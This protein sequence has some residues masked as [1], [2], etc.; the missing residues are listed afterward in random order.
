MLKLITF[1][2]RDD[3]GRALIEVFRPDDDFVK[4]AS[5]DLWGPTQDFLQTLSSKSGK[6]YILVNALGASE[7]WGN[8]I[9]GDI[10]PE[11]EL[12]PTD[13]DCGWGYKTF[14]NAGV[15]RHHA[16][17]KDPMHS[18]GRI[19]FTTYNTY[20]HRVELV[21]EIDRVRATEL[22]HGDLIKRIDAGEN[23]A[24]SMGCRVPY[25]VCNKCGHKS[26]TGADHCEH[27][28]SYLNQLIGGVRVGMINIRPKFFDL[29]VV[30]I[31][32]EK[33]SY[34]MAKVA[35][36]TNHLFTENSATLAEMYD[37]NKRS[38]RLRLKE[39]FAEK[40]KLSEILKKIPAMSARVIP[41]VTRA[42]PELSPQLLR[43][44]ARSSLPSALTSTAAAGIL[45]RPR[46]YQH[47]ALSCLGRP[48][49]AESL[50]RRGVVF[51]P[52]SGRDHSV[53]WGAPSMHNRGL[54]SLLAS[55]IPGR[56]ILGHALSKR[57][58]FAGKSRPTPSLREESSPVLEK[59]ASG[60][61]AYREEV[62]TK[63]SS[64][65]A[66]ITTKDVELLSAIWDLELGDS[67]WGGETYGN[68]KTASAWPAMLLG[69][70]PLAYLYGAYKTGKSGGVGEREEG[71]AGFVREHP[72]LATS[73]LVGLT[74]MGDQLRKSGLLDDAVN[75]L[76]HK[77]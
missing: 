1:K 19:V 69:A 76:V 25:D 70:F 53:S 26:R 21:I 59:V 58:Q 41:H 71:I 73:V 12:N 34:V 37:L 68:E 44:L 32:A 61:N 27:V 15:F 50:H 60:Y 3:Q 55:A 57:I 23:P 29:S 17:N 38:L 51:S 74:R 5:G 39:K 7:Y 22:G 75:A 47:I 28:A 65:V 66:N 36:A 30:V 64:V 9:N 10:F 40:K 18:Y 63:I 20:M 31:G 49:M 14:M 54:S 4:V 2:P 16:N 8:N 11:A 6:L 33:S 42:E 13:P 48:S 45:L 46:E 67:D 24:V 72:V 52:S 77:A 43:A 35:S 56:G 62:L